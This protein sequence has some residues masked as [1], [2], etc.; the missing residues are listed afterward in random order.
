M[1]IYKQAACL[2]KP[3]LSYE[4]YVELSLV[5]TCRSQ[6]LLHMAR[7]LQIIGFFLFLLQWTATGAGRRRFSAS[8]NETYCRLNNFGV[9]GVSVIRLFGVNQDFLKF[10]GVCSK[11]HFCKTSHCF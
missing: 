6:Q 8:L 3:I 10:K 1:I 4:K 11:Y 2:I 5:H 7:L 9:S